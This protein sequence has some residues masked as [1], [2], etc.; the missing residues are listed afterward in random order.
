M[1]LNNVTLIPKQLSY[2]LHCWC[3]V[4]FATHDI[5]SLVLATPQKVLKYFLSKTGMISVR[6]M[7]LLNILKGQI[8][9]LVYWKNIFKCM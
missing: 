2:V 1:N 4:L 3:V 6:L 5:W 7:C 9:I 8:I